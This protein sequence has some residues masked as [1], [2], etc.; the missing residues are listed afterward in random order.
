M[1]RYGDHI[2]KEY[3]LRILIFI[4][5]LLAALVGLLNPKPPPALFPHIG[6]VLHCI[7]FATLSLATRIAFRHC[8]AQWL[9]TILLCC[10]PLAEFLQLLQ[11][12][13]SFSRTDIY[14]NLLGVALAALLWFVYTYLKRR[15]QPN[16]MYTNH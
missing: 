16:T 8:P 3:A 2:N 15:W 7:G 6:F 13:R 9:W 11:P 4:V 10:A 14:A 12:L 5:I 1:M